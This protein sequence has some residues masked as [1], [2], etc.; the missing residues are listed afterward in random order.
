[1]PPPNFAER[2]YLAGPKTQF[3][4]LFFGPFSSIL[5]HQHPHTPA[6]VLLL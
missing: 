2:P 4:T 5:S 1:M 3:S 6:I